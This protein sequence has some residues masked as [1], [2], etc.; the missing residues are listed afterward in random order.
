MC[1]I[2]FSPHEHQQ[3][4]EEQWLVKSHETRE[5][6][7]SFSSCF[8]AA[9]MCNRLQSGGVSGLDKTIHVKECMYVCVCMCV[10]VRVCV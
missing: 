6:S 8:T 10:C 4:L 5:I 2:D 1:V 7:V 3:Q 9:L